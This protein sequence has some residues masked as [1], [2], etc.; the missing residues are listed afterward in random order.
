M[1]EYN[2]NIQGGN[3]ATSVVIDKDEYTSRIIDNATLTKVEGLTINADDVKTINVND[4][5]TNINVDDIK[6]D[7]SN[8]IVEV[9]NINIII[10]RDLFKKVIYDIYLK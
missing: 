2:S 9:G 8:F 5:R 6:T 7:G 3:P 1:I 4:I 10:S